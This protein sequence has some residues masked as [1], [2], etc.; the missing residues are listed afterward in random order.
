MDRSSLRR[1]PQRR[2]NGK[3]ARRNSRSRRRYLNS[4][5]SPP[6]VPP[7][8][9]KAFYKFKK[10]RRLTGPQEFS[11]LNSRRKNLA[12]PPLHLCRHAGDVGVVHR[13]HLDVAKL[14]AA[15]GRGDVGARRVDAALGPE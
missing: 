11:P 4:L 12:E 1:N 10:A 6:P 8:N 3:L 13:D 14:G 15:G 2:P 7:E 9:A 5:T